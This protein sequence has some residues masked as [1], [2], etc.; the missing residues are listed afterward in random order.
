MTVVSDSSTREG[1]LR[2]PTSRSPGSSPSSSLYSSTN[3][4]PYWV[5]EACAIKHRRD[6]WR[7]ETTGKSK[8]EILLGT[9]TSSSSSSSSSAIDSSCVS[10]LRS[11]QP[12]NQKEVSKR[13]KARPKRSNKG[14][15]RR[16]LPRRRGSCQTPFAE[17]C[18]RRHTTR[19]RRECRWVYACECTRACVRVRV[20]SGA[21]VCVCV[22][23]CVYVR[24][25]RVDPRVCL[26]VTMNC[27]RARQ[28]PTQQPSKHRFAPCQT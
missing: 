1:D 9:W 6:S 23:V 3:S 28:W 4:S 17:S 15:A 24:V 8:T 26:K 19:L 21:Y 13:H 18:T 7:T 11:R 5:R 27:D 16:R 12:R 20:C 10:Q 25:A 22:C 2:Q 14:N